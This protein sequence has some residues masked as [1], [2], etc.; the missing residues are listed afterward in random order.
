MIELWI[1]L[2]LISLLFYGVAQVISK[3]ALGNLS[4]PSYVFVAT[5][6]S[7][8]I[9]VG[10]LIFHFTFEEPLDAPIQYLVYGLLS[11]AFG[12]VG[13]Y[14]FLEALKRGPVTIVGSITAAYPVMTVVVAI[15]IL[16]ESL[17]VFQ[18]IGVTII[19]A[20]MI[21]LSYFHGNGNGKSHLSRMALALSILTFL[22]WGLWTIFIKVALEELSVALY[23]GLYSIIVPPSVI[24]YLKYRKSQGEIIKPK[25]S[26]AVKI[27]LVAIALGQT[28][29][30]FETLSADMGSVSI[31]FPLI[32]AYPAVT[33]LFA[34]LFLKEKISRRE[35]LFLIPVIAG[36]ILISII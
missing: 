5:L 28:A 14:V 9:Y 13:Y 27:A 15:T 24:L 16:G 31:V 11:A 21:G 17:S 35:S 26:L 2:A 4:A 32:A 7:M 33:V 10:L 30:L 8:P 23:L 22:L 6:F 34:F 1:I 18:G 3:S 36:I 25:W 20:G 29:F 19:L 12:H